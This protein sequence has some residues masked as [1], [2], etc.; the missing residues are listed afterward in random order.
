MAERCEEECRQ[1]RERRQS[2]GGERSP[3]GAGPGRGRRRLGRADYENR[4]I[5][6]LGNLDADDA[7]GVGCFVVFREAITQVTGLNAN[8]G[9]GLGVEIRAAVEDLDAD[10]R[11]FER[12]RVTRQ[13]SFHNKTEQPRQAGGI[14]E[15][16]AARMESSWAQTSLAAG[17]ASFMPRED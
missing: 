17:V 12:S 16:L 8:D 3:V 13:A 6:A 9:V 11:F 7:C 2:N 10:Y 14:P 15:L 5:G 1:K 4:N